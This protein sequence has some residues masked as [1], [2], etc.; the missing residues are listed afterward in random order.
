[1]MSNSR[2]RSSCALIIALVLV[3]CGSSS[4]GTQAPADADDEL[5]RGSLPYRDARTSPRDAHGAPDAHTDDAAVPSD[6]GGGTGGDGGG[7]IA[8]AGVV[9]CYSAYAPSATCA[10]PTH[11]CFTNYSAEH[12]GS[13]AT[14]ACTWGTIDCDGP[15][16]CAT[17]QRCCAHVIIDPDDGITGY[18]LACQT[19]ACGAAPANV[20]L[21]HGGST[22]AGTCDGDRAC[23]SAE[24]QDYD[25]PRTLSICR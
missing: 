14:A 9:S 18:K 25:L 5:S 20:E 7:G 12:A 21:C 13:C 24:N 23:V 4:D 19:D 16:D 22:A 8:G 3:A 11:C 6:A 15:E 17:G 1:M 2:S 10:L